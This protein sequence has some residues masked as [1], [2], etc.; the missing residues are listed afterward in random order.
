MF[1]IFSDKKR[2]LLQYID[3]EIDVFTRVIDMNNLDFKKANGND[4]ECLN[5]RTLLLEHNRKHLAVLEEL[6]RIRKEIERIY[7]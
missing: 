6:R 7:G 1:D 2:K 5:I 4:Q 3:D